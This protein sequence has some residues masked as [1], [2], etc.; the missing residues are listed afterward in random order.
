MTVRADDT[1]EVWAGVFRGTGGAPRP[2][3]PWTPCKVL[4]AR[5]ASLYVSPLGGALS[6]I[7]VPHPSKVVRVPARSTAP[8]VRGEVY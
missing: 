8:V 7:T 4:D 5:E 1:V 6:P 3:D 2:G